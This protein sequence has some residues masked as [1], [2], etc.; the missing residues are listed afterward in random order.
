[1]GNLAA[2]ATAKKARARMMDFMMMILKMVKFQKLRKKY[3]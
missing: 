1:V 2:L 3:I